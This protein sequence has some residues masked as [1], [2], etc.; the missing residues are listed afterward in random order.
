MKLIV[1][2]MKQ[3]NPSLVKDIQNEQKIV[4]LIGNKLQTIENLLQCRNFTTE[5]LR[6]KQ[7]RQV[8]RHIND[9]L[10]LVLI[11][12]ELNNEQNDFDRPAFIR[13]FQQSG[14][15]IAR[16]ETY[17][18]NAVQQNPKKNELYYVQKS[19]LNYIEDI[20]QELEL[21]DKSKSE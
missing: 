16:I 5:D 2:K 15:Q 14:P 21:K 4:S 10:L 3:S 13:K 1:G 18:N 8:T 6:L 12:Q 19:G 7:Y 11:H 9:T 20:R 17:L